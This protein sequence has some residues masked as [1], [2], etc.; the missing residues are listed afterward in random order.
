MKALGAT[1]VLSVP[2]PVRRAIIGNAIKPG[3]LITD[4]EQPQPHHDEEI[5]AASGGMFH[6]GCTCAIGARR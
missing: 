1:T 3:R 6:P 2:A 4:G 5:I